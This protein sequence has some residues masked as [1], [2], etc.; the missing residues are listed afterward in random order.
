MSKC[1]VSERREGNIDIQNEY[2]KIKSFLDNAESEGDITRKTRN[3]I[4]DN[5]WLLFTL[6]SQQQ[7]MIGTRNVVD[8]DKELYKVLLFAE[9][10][11]LTL[12]EMLLLKTEHTEESVQSMDNVLYRIANTKLML[13]ESRAK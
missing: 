3:F 7:E 13:S 4:Q 1:S 6:I 5:F 8:Y 2:E 11:I 9:N 12:N 10:K